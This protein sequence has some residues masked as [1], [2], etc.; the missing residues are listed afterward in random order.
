MIRIQS[1]RPLRD[2]DSQGM[3]RDQG[4]QR[5]EP[6]LFEVMGNVHRRTFLSDSDLEGDMRAIGQVRASPS[7]RSSLAAAQS[8]ILLTLDDRSRI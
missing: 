3:L 8:R 7:M 2:E 5:L 4:M 1:S 6:G